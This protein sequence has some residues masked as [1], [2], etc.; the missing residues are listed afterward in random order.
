M[1]NSFC[2]A[3]QTLVI[4]NEEAIVRSSLALDGSI[5][6][7]MISGFATHEEGTKVGGDIYFAEK[8]LPAFLGAKGDL[9]ANCFNSSLE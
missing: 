9:F 8:S 5:V 4:V 6:Y 1:Q 3:C 7:D 2:D